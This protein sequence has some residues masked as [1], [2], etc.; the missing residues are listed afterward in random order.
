MKALSEVSFSSSQKSA[1]SRAR[2]Q[3]MRLQE[4]REFQQQQEERR[5]IAEEKATQEHRKYL[6]E[7]YRLL[8]EALSEKSSRRSENGS[9]SCS[10]ASSR[11]I[12]W[13]QK[14]SQ[15]Q[16]IV[17]DV[18]GLSRDRP[19]TPVDTMEPT[20]ITGRFVQ[21]RIRFEPNAH[22]GFTS[23]IETGQ[24]FDLRS[25]IQSTHTGAATTAAARRPPP[26]PPQPNHF[27]QGGMPSNP[28]GDPLTW[29]SRPPFNSTTFDGQV[30]APPA[31]S[32]GVH[33]RNPQ[34]GIRGLHG[35]SQEESQDEFQLSRSQ[36]AARQAV[37]RDLPTFSGNPEEWPIFL[38]MYNRTT[39]MCGFNEEENLQ[40][41]LKGKAYEAVK[42]RLMFPGNVS[43]I[44]STLKMLFGQPEVI[45]QSLIEKVSSLPAIREDKL[46]TLVDFAV[47]VQNFCATVDACGLQEYMYNITMLHQ[48][49]SKLPSSLKLNWAQHRLMEPTANLATFSRWIYSLTEAASIVTFSPPVQHEKLSR[50]EVHGSKKGN[51]NDNCCKH[52]AQNLL[53]SDWLLKYKCSRQPQTFASQSR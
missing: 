9:K 15:M 42:S 40:N 22:T 27:R 33:H 45:I 25:A 2:L 1:V 14:T 43:G 10:E 50:N 39:T 36:V 13:V 12:D 17:P 37:P 8:E 4:E 5:R 53:A 23:N 21:P 28:N 44:L 30:L 18:S 51:C 29:S 52:C 19:H 38:S 48:I 24:Q 6:E 46:D 34:S 20:Q 47:H 3:L 35:L 31:W 49:V 16:Q 7:K 26:R 41:S 32:T 11:M